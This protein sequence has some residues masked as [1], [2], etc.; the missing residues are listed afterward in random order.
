[1]L[2]KLKKIKHISEY[3]EQKLAEIGEHNRSVGVDESDLIN[4]AIAMNPWLVLC[5]VIAF[6]LFL[7]PN[8]RRNMVTLNI[9]C[10]LIYSGVYIEKGLAEET[11][12]QVLV[13]AL[14]SAYR[15]RPDAAEEQEV[16]SLQQASEQAEIKA[17]RAALIASEGRRTEAAQLL[18]ISR[19]TL[20]E[21]VKHYE[22]SVDV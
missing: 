4:A 14:A 22:I 20:W 17:I 5:G 6:I 13:D 16:M 3:V 11:L 12:L 21:K 2:D 10:L 8:T 7:L 19:K 18:G 1:M 9:G 15:K